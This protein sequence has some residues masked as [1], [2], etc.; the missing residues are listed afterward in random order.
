MANST[1]G[2]YNHPMETFGVLFDSPA[3]VKIMRLFLFNQEQTFDFSD[4]CDKS[5]TSSSEARKE[6]SLLQKAH[7][8]KSKIFYKKIIKE[9]GG[10]ELELK[11]KEKGWGLDYNFPYLSALQSFLL[12]TKSLERTNI[13]KKLSTTG[14]LKFVLVAGIF[15]QDPDSRMDMLVV[16]DNM[17]KSSVERAIKTIESEIGKELT[18]S[19][20]ETEDFKYRLGMYDKLIRDALDYPHKVLLDKLILQK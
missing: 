2:C 11:K 14:K 19:F 16:G 17:R 1:T 10:K 12:S 8:I 15:I 3:R 13:V 18:Y 4:I 5:K 9:K 7:L 6:L 20:F